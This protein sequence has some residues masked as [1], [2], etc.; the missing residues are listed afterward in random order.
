MHNHHLSV[1]KV[2]NSFRGKCSC[3]EA[4]PLRE[5]RWEAEDWGTEHLK[6][7]ERTRLHLDSPPTLARSAKL[8]R[9]AA[10]RPDVTPANA[11]L[12]V[13]M[14]DEIEHRLEGSTA[15]SEQLALFEDEDS[16]SSQA[17]RP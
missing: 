5:H 11:L 15:G 17:T 6:R 3:R 7:I 12:F 16:K 4:G 13:Q 1:V 10:Q 2:G 9:E 8:Y 14:A